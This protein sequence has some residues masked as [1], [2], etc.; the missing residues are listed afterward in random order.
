MMEA[1]QYN[2]W[3]K[4]SIGYTAQ[5]LKAY[6]ANPVWT[7][8]PKAT[9]YRDGPKL[10]LDHGYCGAARLRVGGLPGR[11][12]RGRHG[13]RGGERSQTSKEAAER[14]Q[15]RAERYYKL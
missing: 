13:R 10:M 8:D 2:P 5:P 3:L 9:P 11:L 6:E 7:E 14:A 4:A 15:K 12:H 1:D